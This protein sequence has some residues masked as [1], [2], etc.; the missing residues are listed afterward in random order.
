MRVRVPSSPRK[1][2]RGYCNGSMADDGSVGEGSSPS[3]RAMSVGTAW[4]PAYTSAEVV[5]ALQRWG[6]THAVVG[7]DYR[8]LRHPSGRLHRV[9]KKRNARVRQDLMNEI[10]NGLQVE[11]ER[12]FAGPKRAEPSEVAEGQQQQDAPMVPSERPP[13]EPRP[14]SLPAVPMPTPVIT[15]SRLDTPARRAV[16]LWLHQQGGSVKDRNGY[17]TA[18]VAK[19]LGKQSTA[20][21]QLLRHMEKDKQIIRD[22]VD[23]EKHKLNSRR[24]YEMILCYDGPNV[25][26]TVAS[27]VLVAPSEPVV[28][29]IPTEPV[30]GPV[31]ATESPAAPTV[32]DLRKPEPESSGV[33]VDYD[34]LADA[35]VAS[36][37]RRL[38]RAD[39]EEAL[40]QRLHELQLKHGRVVDY[41]RRLRRENQ[42]LQGYGDRRRPEI[43]GPEGV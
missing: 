2:S 35:V 30:P 23:P 10:L 42:E 38:T 28:A 34:R 16:I 12:F 24:T 17:L 33:E 36:L 13:E 29:L 18:W 43:E 11:E 22:N 40:R 25:A 15:D 1:V 26:A 4:A 32:V 37:V 5:A 14:V 21:L 3:P 31:A 19:E 20:V 7:K 6:F 9:P 39:S 27:V 8:T 41:A